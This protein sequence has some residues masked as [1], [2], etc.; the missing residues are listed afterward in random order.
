MIDGP[1]KN[2][3]L[4]RYWGRFFQALCN[5]AYS[6][7]E[8]AAL[9]QQAVGMELLTP[10]T[11][12]LLMNLRSYCRDPQGKIDPEI[13]IA[14]IFDEGVTSPFVDHLRRDISS[15]LAGA[16][17]YRALLHAL[18]SAVEQQVVAADS[19][20]AEECTYRDARGQLNGISAEGVQFRRSE[21]LSG[22]SFGEIRD[23]LLEG[24][25]KAFKVSKKDDLEDGP[26][27]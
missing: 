5:D 26:P 4:G 18:D 1:P 22:I 2:F 21:A 16:D 7:P 27:A 11:K 17:L 25:R 12:A 9:A 20:L 8:R 23:K 15:R 10:E 13:D 3:R 19:R 6:P 14:D 24:Q